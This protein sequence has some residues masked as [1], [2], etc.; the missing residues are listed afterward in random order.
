MLFYGENKY[1]I[2]ILT[3]NLGLKP[4]FMPFC[5]QL[6]HCSGGSGLMVL[7]PSTSELRVAFQAVYYPSEFTP[8]RN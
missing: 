4:P 7:D 6:G 1:L 2:I 3:L 8:P 5:L